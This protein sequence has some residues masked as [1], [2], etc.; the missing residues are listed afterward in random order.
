MMA[1]GTICPLEDIYNLNMRIRKGGD[2]PLHLMPTDERLT[3]VIDA[4]S[5]LSSLFSVWNCYDKVFRK[6]ARQMWFKYQQVGWMAS[7]VK[8]I[9]CADKDEEK[10]V[11]LY[12]R[13][14]EHRRYELIAQLA[15]MNRFHYRAFLTAISLEGKPE[16]TIFFRRSKLDNGITST[17]A[18]LKYANLSN[19]II[20]LKNN[21]ALL[22]NENINIFHIRIKKYFK[23]VLRMFSSVRIFQLEQDEKHLKQKFASVVEEILEPGEYTDDEANRLIDLL[24][25]SCDSMCEYA[26]AAKSPP[27][28][29]RLSH[30]YFHSNII[31][32]QASRTHCVMVYWALGLP[33]SLA[34]RFINKEWLFIR[35]KDAVFLST[36]EIKQIYVYC[37]RKMTANEVLMQT[38]AANPDLKSS[39]G[40]LQYK[41]TCNMFFTISTRN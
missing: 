25:R 23:L 39:S 12:R 10:I 4:I 7:Q 8:K 13:C 11:M 38:I 22:G 18:F 33:I 30:E 17:I 34:Q 35:D 29:Y 28:L 19:L 41:L 21:N 24:G 27:S 37:T 16:E 36:E 20:Q 9:G 40:F 1:E 3:D 2:C 26:E 5:S 6:E 14:I 15:H 31:G 32:T